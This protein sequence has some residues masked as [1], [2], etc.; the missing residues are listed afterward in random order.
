MKSLVKG[1]LIA[2]AMLSF[3]VA[4]N[5]EEAPTL[6]A[7]TTES[8]SMSFNYGDNTFT[9]TDNTAKDSETELTVMLVK[10]DYTGNKSLADVKSDD[11]CYIGQ[12]GGLS[13]SSLFTNLGVKYTGG[14]F[15][16]GDYTLVKSGEGMTEASKTKIFLGNARKANGGISDD[17]HQYFKD[18]NRNVTFGTMSQTLKVYEDANTGQYIYIGVGN[19]PLEGNV[20]PDKLGFAVQKM[21]DGNSVDKG[22]RSLDS[23]TNISDSL[24]NIGSFEG[25][26]I[27]VGIQIKGINN[28]TEIVAIP[29][30]L[31]TAE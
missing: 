10:G 31:G 15:A 27:E 24:K 13:Y 21:V 25:G 12:Q 18:S 9:V 5:A 28:N 26:S 23:F 14:E 11:I 6:P 3:A 29:Y 19:F 4:A 1:F 20:T 8:I 16:P 7:H 22:Y 30:V 17:I 2:A